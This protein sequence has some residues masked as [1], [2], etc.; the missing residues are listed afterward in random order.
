MRKFKSVLA[1]LLALVLVLGC[2]GTAFAAKTPVSELEGVSKGD[3]A[4]AKGFKSVEFQ[5]N[6][7]KYNDDDVVRAIVVLKDA[8]TAAVAKRGAANEASV[9]AQV[10]AS[11]DKVRK[12]MRGIDY[13][14]QYTYDTLLNGFSCDVAY[15]DLDKIASI[16]GV[17]A[18]YIANHYAAPV[19][20]KGRE[21]KTVG[22][23][24]MT[25]TDQA[26]EEF[27]VD[28]SGIVVAVLDTGL[29][30][31]HEAFQDADESCKDTGRLTANDAALAVADGKYVN[32]KI[33]FAYDYAEK[34]NDVT[35][36]NGHGTHVSGIIAGNAY[37]AKE[38]AYTFQGAAPAAQIVSMKIFYDNK[39]GTSSDIYF[40]ALEDAYRLG[41]DVVNMSIG[42]QNGFTYDS[43]LETEVFGNIYKRLS[44]AGI[45]LSVAAGNEYSMAENS[46]V[47]Y[48]GPE[49]QDYGTVASPSTYIGST[50]VASVENYC[51]PSYYVTV[52][53]EKF[54]YTDTCEIKSKTW[55]NVFGGEDA[56]YV[57]VKDTTGKNQ[58]SD[59]SLG[60]PEDFKA[61][62]VKGKIAIIQRGELDFSTK[63]VNA[64]DAGA[65][66]VIV[67]NNQSGTIRMSVSDF[68]I[69][70]IATPY[71][72]QEAFLNAE[73]K[74]VFTSKEKGNVLNSNAGL[75]DDFSNWGT[76]PM[77]TMAP[78]I[79][80]VGGQ[81][82]SAVQT[83]NHDYDIYSGTSMAA[84]NFAGSVALV[85]QYLNE[86]DA[87]GEDGGEIILSNGENGSLTKAEKADLALALLEGTATILTEEDAAGN[88]FPYSV[89]KQGA[90]LTDVY[91]AL[92]NYTYSGYITNPLQELGDDAKKTGV[93]EFD[94]TL[95]NGF[96][97]S[98]AY[99]PASVLTYDYVYNYNESD[100]SKAPLYINSL[101]EDVLLEGED[102]TAAYTIDGAAV[103]EAIVIKPE[104]EVTVHVKL[105]LGE[106]AKDYFDKMFEN[107][108]YID[109]FV[110][111]FETYAM[112]DGTLVYFDEDNNVYAY[113]ETGAYELTYD[114]DNNFVAKLDED[115]KK[116]YYTGE[117]S[118]AP[119]FDEYTANHA[120]LL[121]FY[122]DWT[123]GNAMESADF[124]DY[125]TYDYF[126][127][128]TVA[129]AEGKTYAE[130]GYSGLSFIDFYTLPNM[131]Y[132]VSNR[133]G[134][135]EV[136][137]KPGA[138]AT[139][140]E[141]KWGAKPAEFMEEHMAMSTAAYKGDYNWT[142]ELY[143]VPQLLR[144]VSHL[145]MTVRDKDT[146][147]LY[148]KDDTPYAIKSVYDDDEDAWAASTVF[149]WDG[150]DT[151]GEYVPSGT[152]AHVQ[153]DAQLP[154]NDAVQE[155]VWEF[156][157]TVD[158]T[159]PKIESAV[160]DKD[161][162]TLTVTASDEQYLQGIY[163]GTKSTGLKAQSFSSDE[164]GASFTAT[165]DVSEL[166]KK[167]DYLYAIAVD[168]A[169]NETQVLV[170]LFD[171][172]KDVKVTVVSATG[173]EV[174]EMKSGDTFVIPT[175]EDYEEAQFQLWG[176]KPVE[177]A[178][179]AK[180]ALAAC[181]KTYQPGDE[182][183]LKS[184]LTIYAVYAY[185][186]T[187][188]L[189]TTNYWYEEGPDDYSGEWAL[190]GLDYDY[191]AEEFLTDTPYVLDSALAKKDVVADFGAKVGEEY[192]EFFTN[193]KSIRWAVE[194]QEDGTYTI[195]NVVTGEYL[196]SS[197]DGLN[198]VML[199]DVTTF[200]K[201]KIK[202]NA[203]YGSTLENVGAK[204]Q[205]LVYDND[206]GVF[207]M[208]DNNEDLSFGVFENPMYAGDLYPI[209]MYHAADEEF[210]ISY[211]TT[212]YCKHS[213]T[214]V[215]GA[216]A[217][218][219]GEDGYT[220]DTYCTVCGKLVKKGEVI[221][222]TGYPAC[223]FKNFKDCGSK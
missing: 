94:V 58:V 221:P 17:D 176:S 139:A 5:A 80:S 106:E 162:K 91:Y 182:V 216:K 175:A 122:G 168:Y 167:Y 70:A 105:T 31:T 203:A 165:F 137:S 1:L 90:G 39:S 117:D 111:F 171:S 188:S 134:K 12:A 6:L 184:D 120:T 205:A 140:L 170:P 18:V 210:V 78:A 159:A 84:P 29:N 26:V 141:E 48:I 132:L 126:S 13:E 212:E 68:K 76:S 187:E 115:N 34:D 60:A 61:V 110:Q 101:T 21:T 196:A 54:S 151:S 57:I 148:Y 2:V 9:R 149:V 155:A 62:D 30:T 163:I 77:L 22:S 204:G 153:Y 156:D 40:Y 85:L 93:Y 35:D 147:E 16:D 75:M 96:N 83:G 87:T 52:N 129:N 166:E 206:E 146:G 157:I 186:K 194:K 218:T 198:M 42:A 202:S 79:T 150:K 179:T 169:T 118:L 197:E 107:G 185:G 69:P 189:E 131:A 32:A 56:E 215:R 51:Y 4:E 181:G 15:G 192:V 103:K 108:N 199:K 8:P 145:V 27:G 45:V 211:Y 41:V 119:S 208:M 113:D 64:A 46:S 178:E 214:E 82:Y 133:Y 219:Y 10:K 14:V 143:M 114:S 59:L 207:T 220:G 73:E 100:P 201:W 86:Q 71:A 138:I 116:I 135:R 53:G 128:T 7:N 65:I 124:R 95:A 89:R 136:R 74:S 44:A 88:E 72:S 102:Y 183:L 142:N 177:K 23:A 37:D 33:P 173:T 3:A 109:G 180:D 66:G 154:Y 112:A 43:S 98:V 174:H 24:I 99:Y 38:G 50:S 63:V 200:A 193:E 47:D 19:L 97:Q 25:G 209:F 28:G 144:N 104:S 20:E 130:L 81:V 164:K 92:S 217:A 161:A 125:L 191:G 11:Q 223:S 160:Y 127:K 36:H 49:Y 195:K 190:A 172:G 152:V 158:Y 213:S 123:K 55:L 222:A 67:V 121:A